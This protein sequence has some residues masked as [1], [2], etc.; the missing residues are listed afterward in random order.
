VNTR[1][2]VASSVDVLHHDEALEVRHEGVALRRRDHQ[3]QRV[4]IA[5]V[6][7]R[8]A[9]QLALHR[10]HGRVDAVAHG[11]RPD[12]GGHHAAQPRELRSS[13]RT[14]ITARSSSQSAPAPSRS[15]RT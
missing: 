9:Q 13:P 7:E 2:D 11:E 3:P 14:V 5:R 4:V 8:V 12:V 15:T 6:D 1:S 10:D